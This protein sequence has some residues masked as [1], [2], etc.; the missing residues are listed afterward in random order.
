M[1][2]QENLYKKKCGVQIIFLFL[3]GFYNI[4]CRSLGL[5]FMLKKTITGGDNLGK[6]DRVQPSKADQVNLI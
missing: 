1:D 6:A 2:Y 5:N 4:N 3:I